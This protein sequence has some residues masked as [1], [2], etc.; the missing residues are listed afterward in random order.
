MSV[1]QEYDLFSSDFFAEP[2]PILNDMRLS[3]PV[4]WCRRLESWVLTRYQDISH[5]IRDINF[6][7]D[8]NGQISRG[9]SQF[10]R[11]K[12]NFCNGFFA[13]WMVFSDPPRHTFLRSIASQVFTHQKMESYKHCIEHLTS[14]LIQNLRAKRQIELIQDF[15]IPLPTLVTAKMF[16][17]PLA[18]VTEL[19]DWSSGI[20][21]LLGA[22][23]ASDEEINL[24]YHN[25]VKCI[26]YFQDLVDK[27]LNSKTNSLIYQLANTSESGY[28]LSREEVATLCIVMMAGAYETTTHLIA[29]GMLA[30]LQNPAQ[31][32]KL[33]DNPPLIDS[34]VEE[35]LRYCGPA[36]SVVRRAKSDTQINGQNIQA[37]QKIYCLLH[38]GNHDP[39]RF[40]QPSQLDISRQDNRHLGLGLGIHFCL[41]AVLTRLETRIAIHSLI[42]NFPNMYLNSSKLDWIPNFAMRGLKNL[43]IALS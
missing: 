16:D 11:D 31:L 8:R 36:F 2:E 38:A 29:N 24:T 22:E 32:S 34:A 21:T 4:Y 39:E 40:H 7:V 33:K 3:N 43:P 10:T 23:N 18:H 17:I 42:Q 41:G 35:L 30:L 27:H 20:F 37:G 1:V 14:E 6:C 15:A 5:T 25:L 12:L 28:K 9:G 19:K 26:K 13:S